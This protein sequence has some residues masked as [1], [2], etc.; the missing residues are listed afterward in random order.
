M[1]DRGGEGSGGS[2]SD[3]M[4]IS[5]DRSNLGKSLEKLTRPLYLK[6]KFE[7]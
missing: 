3:L 7:T 6:N 4:L 2:G 5:Q 1:R